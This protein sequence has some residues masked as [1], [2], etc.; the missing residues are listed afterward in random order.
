M[1]K[2]LLALLLAALMVVSLLPTVAFAGE[3]TDCTYTQKVNA[4]VSEEAYQL[5]LGGKD[6]GEFT[7]EANGTGWNIKNSEGKYL[8]AENGK[9]V[10]GDTAVTAWTYKN[11]AFSTSV[12]TTQKSDGYW[13]LF[14][15]V[16]GR[17]SKTVTTTYYLNTVTD[18]QK[19]STNTVRAELYTAVSGAHDY[20]YVSKG[21]GTHDKVCRN[22]DDTVNEP[23]DYDE[24]THKCVCGAYDPAESSVKISVVDVKE[25]TT[26]QSVGILGWL[27]GRYK[28]VT[29]YTA[30]IKTEAKG[31]RVTKVQYQLNGGGRWTNGTSVSS[32]KPIETLKVKAWDNNG[33]LYEYEW[34]EEPDKTSYNVT[35]Q[36]QGDHGTAT[37][38]ADSVDVAEA[39]AGTSVVF[40]ATAD[41]GYAFDYWE[42]VSGG[43]DIEADKTDN[44]LTVTMPET[45]LTVKAHFAKVYAVVVEANGHGTASADKTIGV[46]GDEVNLTITPDE[47]Y[48]VDQI[49]VIRGGVSVEENKFTIGT[50]DV[51]IQVTFKEIAPDSYGIIL[52]DDDHGTAKAQV[53]GVD[54]TSAAPEATV[55]LTATPNDGYAFKEW[56]IARGLEAGAIT[57]N[58]FT[59]PANEVK[60]KAIFER[61]YNINL[62]TNEHGTASA[63]VGGKTVTAAAANAEVTLTATPDEGYQLKEWKVVS[64]GVTVTDNKF[65]MPA[66]NVTVQAVF[67]EI[68]ETKTVADIIATVD[69]D[70]PTAEETAWKNKGGERFSFKS[71]TNL[72]FRNGVMMTNREINLTS[73]VEKNTENNYVHTGSNYTITFVMSDDKLSAITFTTEDETLD[74]YNGTYTA[75]A[76][77]F[78]VTFASAEHGAIY[79]AAT[80]GQ[81]VT[82][83]SVA[84]GAAVTFTGNKITIGGTD[85]YAVAD[86]G[87]KFKEFSATV[88]E[89]ITAATTI[90]PVFEETI[91]DGYYLIGPEWSIDYIDPN[92]KFEANPVAQGEFTL[93]TTLTSGQKIKVVKVESNNITTFYPDGDGTE[94]T[95]DA[96]HTGDVTI[97]FQNTYNE[98]WND[99]GGFFYVQS[100]AVTV[101]FAT[102]EHGAV[103]DAEES[104]QKV[105]SISVVKGAAVAV[106][107]NK[108]TIGDTDYYAVADSG[109]EF[110]EFSATVPET[111]TAATT[112]TPVFEKAKTIKAVYDTTGDANTLTIYYDNIDHSG[113]NKTVYSNLYTAPTATEVPRVMTPEETGG[114]GDDDDIFSEEIKAWIAYRD[115]LSGAWA[116]DGVR[117][118]VKSVTIDE[119]VKDY[120][121]LTSTA[122]MFYNMVNAKSITGAEYLNVSKVTNMRSMFERFGEKAKSMNSVPNTADWN[123]GNVTLMNDMFRYY[124]YDSTEL[125]CVPNTA[126]WNT[127]NVTNMNHMFTC[128]GNSSENMSVVPDVKGWNTA[129]VTDMGS[130]FCNYGY[131]STELNAV[132]DVSGWNTSSV[133]DM[134][135]MFMSYADFSA[136]INEVPDVSKWKTSNAE[137]ISSMFQG[138]GTMSEVLDKV[139]DVSG[140][141]TSNV[142]DMSFM[143]NAYAF[144]SASINEV[145]AVSGWNTSKA[146]NISY[147]F[148]SY[149]YMSKV[150]D[151]VP[152]V[153]NWD[154]SNVED[155]SFV[156]NCYAMAFAPINEVPDVSNWVTTNAE[157]ISGMFRKYGST[158]SVLD[159]VP[160]V[161]QWDTS[162]VKDMSYVFDGYAMVSASINAVPDVSNWV[163]TNAENISG[164]FSSY[165]QLSESLNCVPAVDNWD[166]SNVTDMSAMF[167][168]YG[169]SSSVLEKVPKVDGF[170]TSKVESFSLSDSSGNYTGLFEAYGTSSNVLNFTLDLSNWDLSSLKTYQ[171]TFKNAG[172]RAKNWNVTIPTT[173]SLTDGGTIDNYKLCWNLPDGA[174]YITPAEGKKFTC[175]GGLTFKAV[176]D[177][178]GDENTLTF[179]FDKID[180]GADGETIILYDDLPNK[181]VSYWDWEYCEIA[182]NVKSVVIDESVKNYHGLIS[183]SSMF[184]DMSYAESISGA[185]Y[186]DV[187]N[188]TDMSCMFSNYGYNSTVLEDVPDVSGWN[189][190]NVTDM[191]NMFSGYGH[192]STA[193]TAVPDV[194]GWNT[195]NV[196]D[197]NGIF[198]GYGSS[199]ET[200]AAVPDVSGWNT[201]KVLDMSSMFYYYGNDST[202]LVFRLDLSNWSLKSLESADSM[203]YSAG[204]YAPLWKVIIP[205]K[206]GETDNDDT[207]WYIGD[208][209]DPESYIEPDEYRNFS[210]PGVASFKAVYKTK[211]D[212]NVLIFY[213]DEKDVEYLD[214]NSTLFDNLP[215]AAEAEYSWDYNGI[216][217]DVKSVVIDESVKNYHNLTSTAYMFYGMSYAE[218][219]T[220]LDNLDVSNVTDMSYMFYCYGSESESSVFKLDLSAWSLDSLESATDMFYGAGYWDALL[221]KVIIPAKTGETDNDATH[222]YNGDGTAYIVPAEERKFSFP[223]AS[224]KAV[225]NENEGEAVLTFYYDENDVEYLDDDS[226]LFDNISVNE[227]GYWDYGECA[228]YVKSVVIDESVKN[229]DGLTST[230]NMFAGMFYAESIDGLDNLDVSNVTDMSYM[231]SGFGSECVELTYVPDVS[232]WNTASV[233]NM[234]GMFLSYGCNSESL[235]FELDLSHWSLDLLANAEDMFCDAGCNA[236]TW[237][238]KI[239]AKTG[240]YDNSATAWC[241]KDGSTISPCGDKQFTVVSEE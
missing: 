221:W 18:G 106:D 226:M 144:Y 204:Y 182:E 112:I 72:I 214:E 125:T 133:K 34:P 180:H 19:L 16:P 191:S 41:E 12:K 158:S 233:T 200:L 195:K 168:D 215:A 216:V 175:E 239:P 139:P 238:V 53:N 217:E 192:E 116:Y 14:W 210:F 122:F 164:M 11:G 150:L 128:Y 89:T 229:Y 79:D 42:V 23:C 240:T 205:A 119:S 199:S 237:S 129:K 172:S 77:K 198:N 92:E 143:F 2:K 47:G 131:S 59:M 209:T 66:V 121:G 222:W 156:F 64:G 189:T 176:Y 132:P 4:P 111:I 76:P 130:I 26:K 185:E 15:Y 218:S 162:N 147:M 110:K 206:T 160:D 33:N 146:E 104:G 48:E 211:D 194:S 208:G 96:A 167:A 103:Y 88:S 22:C 90:T 196:T 166:T 114:G 183:T 40:E 71:A 84:S 108:I 178:T 68:P 165:G 134:S 227:Y 24:T 7:F 93:S 98:L 74:R 142:K 83:I 3:V 57:D 6:K 141:V 36:V 91:A 67:E 13:F 177:T 45:A 94:Y 50:A 181:A 173:T 171:N 188:V 203:F 220:G 20:K 115:A 80:S 163:T 148:G 223:G 207:H 54:V 154:T 17:G 46:S 234:E 52:E 212:A 159:K 184:S 118:Y 126:K 197:M 225:Y 73:S 170:E 85:Y 8:N 27:F 101:T 75:P 135:D 39:T 127:E 157:N 224:F 1:K 213:Y 43:I 153:S 56:E 105:T 62:Q 5:K 149:G 58:S 231:F 99:F 113:E 137:D 32:N 145:P 202:A 232:G 235:V 28:T 152:D 174:S 95:V 37:A 161:S 138:Y 29:T 201:E 21:N 87:Y 179:Y 69:G 25:K 35:A 86:S 230:S 55:T 38:K 30:T 81:K 117:K 100:N 61:V 136:S 241:L 228:E 155:M 65:T 187:S 120:T 219:I 97:Y 124:G 193:L 82:S 151:K 109:Y 140:W 169:R 107:G 78:T 51:K 190:E 186:L 60:V 236:E 10:L 70:F 123:T 49:N 102:A 9:L 31:V 63:T 44:P